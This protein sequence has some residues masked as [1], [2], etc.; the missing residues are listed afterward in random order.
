M[1]SQIEE[2]ISWASSPGVRKS[3]IGNRSRDTTPELQVRRYLHASGLRY[4]VHARPIKDWNRRA[5]IVFPA[6]KIAVFVNG[7]FWHGCPKH[8]TEPKTNVKYWAPKIKRNIERD[9]ETFSRLKSD[10]WMVIQIWEHED[11]VKG[12]EKAVIKIRKRLLR[13]Q[14]IARN[15]HV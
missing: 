4:R 10:G 3:M 15:E 6:A 1:A 13:I 11:L 9:L 5:D 14:N 7:C 2:R 8:Y 12:A